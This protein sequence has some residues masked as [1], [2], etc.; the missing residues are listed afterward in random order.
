MTPAPQP[1]EMTLFD[2][3]REVVRQRDPLADRAIQS[4]EPL[5]PEPQPQN[6]EEQA[7][8]AYRCRQRNEPPQTFTPPRKAFIGEW[9]HLLLLAAVVAPE[10]IRGN[11]EAGARSLKRWISHLHTPDHARHRR[12]AIARLSRSSHAGFVDLLDERCERADALL[13][14]AGKAGTFTTTGLIGT[15]LKHFGAEIWRGPLH[16]DHWVERLTLGNHTVIGGVSTLTAP[17]GNAKL[18]SDLDALPGRL[19]QTRDRA[20]GKPI[21]PGEKP[22]LERTKPPPTAP[23]AAGGARRG[24]RPG[25]TNL[26]RREREAAYQKIRDLREKGESWIRAIDRLKRAQVIK[27]LPGRGGDRDSKIKALARVCGELERPN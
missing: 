21:C 11:K 27:H 14:E 5:S 16:V 3:L 6:P 23:E 22:E 20:S 7:I 13:A 25:Q 24:P 10:R 4:A 19:Q 1:L 2:R 8:A 26:I 17:A 12:K 9:E 18:P 15:E